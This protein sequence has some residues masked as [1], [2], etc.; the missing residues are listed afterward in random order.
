M[1]NILNFEDFVNEGLTAKQKRL[2]KGLQ[3]A[4]LK[5]QGKTSKKKDSDKEEKE[6]KP[7]KKSAGKKGL[8]AKQQ[9]LPEGLKKAILKR[10]K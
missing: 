6:E 1:S 8:T 10:Q 4:I 9:K 3:A 5:K 2:P 7:E